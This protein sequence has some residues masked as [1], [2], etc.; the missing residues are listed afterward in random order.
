MFSVRAFLI[1]PMLL[2]AAT[3]ARA[4]IVYNQPSDFPVS[5]AP[6]V[7]ASQ[8]DN[9]PT[10]AGNF[11]TAYDNF[12]LS[13]TTV[14]KGVT[15][16]GAYFLPPNA[17]TGAD[18]ITAFTLTFWSDNAGTPG[19]ALLSQTIPGNANES[20]VGMETA[21]TNGG[22]EVF[23]YFDN[24]PIPFTAVGGTQYWLSIVP[25]LFYE[26]APLTDGQWGW[27]TGT[28]GDGESMQDF[29]TVTGDPT[30]LMRFTNP[31]DLAFSLSDTTVSTVPEPASLAVWGLIGIAGGVY[32]WRRCNR[33]Q[34]RR[35]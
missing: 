10:G 13:Q 5:G 2:I 15:W 25:N 12:T 8:N 21:T 20:F 1:V 29:E 27:H 18:A 6:G 28:G 31:H 26:D 32:R 34:A 7:Y 22:N 11:A 16:Q 17:G 19:V 23:N 35:D 4:G 33:P 9:G 30:T 14:I 24:L 3:A